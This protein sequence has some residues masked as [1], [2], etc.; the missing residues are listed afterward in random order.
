MIF[1]SFAAYNFAISGSQYGN[2][3]GLERPLLSSGTNKRKIAYIQD[4]LKDYARDNA[5]ECVKYNMNAET[6][7]KVM[8]ICGG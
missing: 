4:K 7:D 6:I 2:N 8:D 1:A 3:C 5:A